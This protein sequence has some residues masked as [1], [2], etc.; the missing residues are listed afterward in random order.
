MKR[1]HYTI[2]GLA[3]LVASFALAP[4]QAIDPVTDFLS[5]AGPEEG[6]FE[7]PLTP[8][9]A[10]EA[11]FG[12]E[13][14]ELPPGAPTETEER[15][16]INGPG[17]ADEEMPRGRARPGFT[18]EQRRKLVEQR[19]K[20]MKQE[21]PLQTDLRVKQAELALLWLDDEPNEDRI[22][23]KAR[24]IQKVKDQLEELKLRQR[25]ARLKLMTP[26]QRKMM[27]MRGMPGMG[28]GAAGLRAGRGMGRGMNR[29]FRGMGRQF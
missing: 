2:I 15:E 16:I 8:P 11:V 4:A 22:V 20:F 1:S 5:G 13:L 28:R 12:P 7:A 24:D 18:P 9:L 25:I 17:G 10:D 21:G 23:A 14:A 27:Q 3:V 19:I 26:E 6:V 29:G